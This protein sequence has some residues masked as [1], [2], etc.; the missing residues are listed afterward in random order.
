MIVGPASTEADLRV[1]PGHQTTDQPG[2][3]ER[4]G[5]ESRSAMMSLLARVTTTVA[6]SAVANRQ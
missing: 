1:S 5:R 4:I 6:E 3:L 2:A